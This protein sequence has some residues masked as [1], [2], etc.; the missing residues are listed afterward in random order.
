MN[1]NR[2]RLL[3]ATALIGLAPAATSAQA[4]DARP[5]SDTTV[6]L[7]SL[8][9]AVAL[10]STQLSAWTLAL[11]VS[12]AALGIAAWAVSRKASWSGAPLSRWPS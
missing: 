8:E 1:R 6:V 10:L 4:R 3:L 12:G 2:M 7:L 5:A 9:E 11:F